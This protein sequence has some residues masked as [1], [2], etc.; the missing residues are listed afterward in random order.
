MASTTAQPRDETIPLPLADIIGL[1]G[2]ALILLAYLIFPLRSDGSATG[3]AFIDSGTTFPALTLLVGVAAV[4]GAIVNITSLRERA[5]C[6]Y[7]VGL[8]LLGLIFLLD[9]TLRGKAGLALGGWLAMLGS[10]ALIAQLLIPR[11]R[12]VAKAQPSDVIFAIIRIVLATLWFTQI[13]W[14][15]PWANFG[16]PAG[17]LIPQAGTSGLCDWIGREIASPRYPLYKDFLTGIV[18][19]N[20]GWMAYLIVGGEIFICISLLFG[21][22]TRLG[23]LMGFMLGINL[24][25]GLTAVPHE[26]DWTYLMLPLLNLVF[27]VVGGRYFG[28]DAA[29]GNWLD[30]A[31]SEPKANPLLKLAVAFVR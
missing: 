15:L 29:L 7:L 14:K 6:W 18:A 26:W 20:L 11:P 10:I 25:I 23:G 28:L 5:V 19:P 1:V 16:C 22:L 2:G 21:L 17:A 4:V 30:K 3:F 31:A 9:N 27:V 8:G 13:L 12:S 24:F